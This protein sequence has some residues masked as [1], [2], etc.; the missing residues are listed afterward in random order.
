MKTK[1]F[2][3]FATLSFSATSLTTQEAKT[4]YIMKNGAAT[5]EIAVSDIDSIIFYNPSTT[6]K[7][8]IINGVKWATRNVAAPGTFAAKPGDAGMFYQWNRKVGWSA[9]NPMVNSN[10][11]TTWSATRS[12]SATWEKA[13]DP[14]PAG[15]RIPTREDIDKLLDTGKVS[16]EWKTENGV[17]GRRFTDKSTGNSIF[18]PVVGYR[19]NSNGALVYAGSYSDYYGSGPGS[20]YAT[21][22]SSG[23]IRYNGTRICGLS[24]RSVAE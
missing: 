16:H 3:L 18:L 9:T 15:W 20:H 7:G 6:D 10:G 17:N 14:S 5:H 11:T 23:A 8:V 4:M 22:S 2:L 1:L 13:N 12:N 19:Q 21:L 24:I